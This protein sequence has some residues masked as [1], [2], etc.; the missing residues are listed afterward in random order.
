MGWLAFG[1]VQDQPDIQSVAK[2]FRTQTYVEGILR[3]VKDSGLQHAD[4]GWGARW[5][6]KMNLTSMGEGVFSPGGR[7]WG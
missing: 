2:G 1:R 7:R 3:S 4:H 6:A 5:I